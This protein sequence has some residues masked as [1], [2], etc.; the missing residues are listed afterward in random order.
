MIFPFNGFEYYG[1][2]LF[3]PVFLHG[4]A[5]KKPGPD[6]RMIFSSSGT[7]PCLFIRPA[8]GEPARRKI[9]LFLIRTLC[10]KNR[11]WAGKV[12]KKP[13]TARA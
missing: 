13:L 2:G 11:Y 10:N 1:W 12:Q 3:M 4:A 8:H 9:R 7:G 5:W 6:G